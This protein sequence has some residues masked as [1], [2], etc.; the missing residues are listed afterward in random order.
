M[1]LLELLKKQLTGTKLLFHFL[2]WSFHW[3]ASVCFPSAHHGA[4]AEGGSSL[5]NRI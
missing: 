1:P 3:Y 5:T 2:F 4:I